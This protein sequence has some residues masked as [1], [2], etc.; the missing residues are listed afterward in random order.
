MSLRLRA[1][2]VSAIVVLAAG[3]VISPTRPAAP[4]PLYYLALGDSLGAGTGAS[5]SA[6]AYV[7]RIVAQ[8][9][10]RFPGLQLQ[11]ISCGGATTASMLTGSNCGNPLTQIVVAENF[12]QA[13]PG[14][15][16]FATIDIGGNDASGCIT[17]AGV[18]A[19]CSAQ[20]A[21]AIQANLPVILSRLKAASPGIKVYG[22]TYYDPALAFWLTGASGQQVARDAVP[23]ADAFNS[24]LTQI[25]GA[26]GFSTADGAGAF[27]N[28]NLALTGSYAGQTVPQNVA[29]LCNWTHVCSDNDVHANDIGHGKLAGA[30]TASIDATSSG[31]APH[32]TSSAPPTWTSGVAQSFAVTASGNPKPKL[33]IVGSLPAGVTFSAHGIGAPIITGTPTETGSFPLVIVAT[34]GVTP[35][36]GQHVTLTVVSAPLS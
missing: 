21:A 6:N 20:S 10:T 1:A 36:A 7:N 19:A 5:T 16:A 3:C 30:F 2:L 34:N 28:D 35:A 22:M 29:N 27:D 33:T 12:L 8:E 17:A 24:E 32:I 4:A 15:V 9:R 26:A 31:V 13:H 11:N 18:N 23:A 25:Y 14:Q